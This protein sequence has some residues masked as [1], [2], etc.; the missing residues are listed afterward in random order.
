MKKKY[1]TKLSVNLNKVA[2]L[3]NSRKEHYISIEEAAVTSIKAGCE[4]ITLHPRADKRHVTIEDIKL[5]SELDIVKQR[6]IEINIEGDLREE[7]ILAVQEYNVDQFTVVPVRLGEKTTERGWNKSD[8]ENLL[9]KTIAK[10]KNKIRIAVFVEPNEKMVD[11]VAFLGVDAVEFHTKWYAQAYGKKQ[12]DDEL[13]K[14]EEASSIA[15]N[16]GLRVNL[17]HDLNLDNL[18]TIIKRVNPDEVSI[19][20]AL[21]ADALNYGLPIIVDKYNRIVKC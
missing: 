12:Q 5:I 20:H 19:G 13:R 9:I 18:A 2:L 7:L 10:L 16:Q 4:G 17:G 21:V 15:R 14:I 1:K 3:R 11:Y 6:K 8:D